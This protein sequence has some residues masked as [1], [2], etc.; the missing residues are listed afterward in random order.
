M[1]SNKNC[2]SVGTAIKDTEI[3]TAINTAY[4]G[5]P[6]VSALRIH[7]HTYKGVVTLTGKVYSQKIA[8]QAVQ[9]AQYTRGVKQVVSN[10]KVESLMG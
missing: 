7:I 2:R 1:S 3:T 4:L 6:T 5:D 10:I 8:D 9:I